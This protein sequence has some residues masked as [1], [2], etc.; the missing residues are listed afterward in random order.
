MISGCWVRGGSGAAAARPLGHAIQHAP[1]QP[2]ASSSHAPPAPRRP[3]APWHLRGSRRQRSRP[4]AWPTASPG[5]GCPPQRAWRR[6]PVRVGQTGEQQRLQKGPARG[7]GPDPARRRQLATGG[8][9]GGAR[10]AHLEL[11]HR[12]LRGPGEQ[13]GV[14]VGHGSRPGCL[15]PTSR[16]PGRSALSAGGCGACPARVQAAGDLC[17]CSGSG[18]GCLIARSTQQAGSRRACSR[19]AARH[20][21]LL[22]PRC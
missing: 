16:L 13:G 15:A 12:Q 14:R 17:K 18:R 19:A 10:G 8:G 2:L 22:P 4:A 3:A 7:G 11:G 20:S 5:A 21:C 9:A 6:Q 1:D